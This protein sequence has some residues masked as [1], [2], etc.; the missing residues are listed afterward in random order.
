MNNLPKS[1]QIKVSNN[2]VHEDTFKE[3]AE[4]YKAAL[5]ENGQNYTLNY[6]PNHIR[7]ENSKASRRE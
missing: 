1:I 4:P 6:T 2:C 3:A 5:N 7:D